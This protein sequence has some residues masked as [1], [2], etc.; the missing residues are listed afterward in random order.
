MRRA[1]TLIAVTALAL[2]A[3]PTAGGTLGKYSPLGVSL[4]PSTEPLLFNVEH[5]AEYDCIEG[6]I[7]VESAAVDG[8]PITPLSV[9]ER[10]GDPNAAAMILPSDT[11]GGTLVVISSCEVQTGPEETSTVYAQGETEF[12]VLAVTKV[13]DGSVPEGTEFTVHVECLATDRAVNGFADPDAV[14]LHYPAVGGVGYV[15]FDQEA[16][17]AIT[18]PGD[19]GALATT[20][21]P[22]QVEI[23]DATT[24]PVTVTNTF[25]VAVEPAFT[26]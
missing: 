11:P 22:D 7:A 4:G 18:E 6:T 14:D 15:Y 21:S 17:C 13:V 12:A 9:T 2:V 23:D 19:G 8:T 26:G 10:V 5:T 16:E 1:L 24:Y 3:F 25:P 20:I